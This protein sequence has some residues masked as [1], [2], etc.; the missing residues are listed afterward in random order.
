MGLVD[1]QQAARAVDMTAF[2]LARS[3]S[4]TKTLG[5]KDKVMILLDEATSDNT[6][7]AGGTGIGGKVGR[8]PNPMSDNDN[9]EASWDRG[10]NELK[11]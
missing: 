5:L 1:I 4:L 8:P 9:T 6:K 11:D 3:L 7:K 2:E 10:S